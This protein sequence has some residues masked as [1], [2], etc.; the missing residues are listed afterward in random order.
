M[1]AENDMHTG[2]LLCNFYV[3]FYGRLLGMV[4]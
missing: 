2:E 1:K 3:S 4:V